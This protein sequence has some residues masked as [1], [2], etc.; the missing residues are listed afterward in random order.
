MLTNPYPDENKH[1]VTARVGA[2]D[3]FYLK[4]LLPMTV[5]MTD[6][7]ISTLYKKF[8]DELRK[9]DSEQPLEQGWYI[10]S[11]TRVVIEQLLT[12]FQRCSTGRVVGQESPRDDAGRIDGIRQ[13]DERAQEQRTDE[14]S[15]VKNRGRSKKKVNKKHD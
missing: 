11:P 14:K 15:A 7:I 9:L 1:F 5:G 2:E 8:V 6:K 12:E 4:R 13:D 10:G 3:Y